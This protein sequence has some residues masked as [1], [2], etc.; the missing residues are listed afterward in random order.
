[1]GA[2]VVSGDLSKLVLTFPTFSMPG[3]DSKRV[4]E[5]SNCPFG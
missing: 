3:T 1:M 5:V 4:F 2:E